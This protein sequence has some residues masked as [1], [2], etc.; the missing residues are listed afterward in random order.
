M[1]RNKW[2]EWFW[3]ASQM[4]RNE[5]REREREIEG[6]ADR[7]KWNDDRC[8]FEEYAMEMNNS[9]ELNSTAEAYDTG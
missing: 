4:W 7:I 8:L 3:S 9:I 1:H 2:N 5:A 6:K